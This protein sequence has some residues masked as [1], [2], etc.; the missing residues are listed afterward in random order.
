MAT[1]PDKNAVI[2]RGERQREYVIDVIGK[3]RLDEAK[4]FVVTI[5]R[6]HK[7]RTLSQNALMWKRYDEV[8][9]ALADETGN[10]IDD[11]HQFAKEQWLLPKISEIG[12]KIVRRWTTTDLDT[13][14]MK[15]FLDKF[16]AWAAS[17]YG[18]IVSRPEDRFAQ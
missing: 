1:D 13:V 18:I 2:L 7:K 16:E 14:Q 12:G 5:S 8:A 17:E 4:P 15:E 10:S 6:Y 9:K 11:I 3:L